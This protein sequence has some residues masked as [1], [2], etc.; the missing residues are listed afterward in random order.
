M[1]IGQSKIASGNSKK[2]SG[3]WRVETDEDRRGRFA[4]ANEYVAPSC[5]SLVPITAQQATAIWPPTDPASAEPRF[6][7]DNGDDDL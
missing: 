6:G 4:P 1:K 3:G 7:N 2:N 5:D